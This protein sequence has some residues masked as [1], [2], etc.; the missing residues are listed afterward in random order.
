MS[1]RTAVVAALLAAAGG[2]LAACSSPLAS[3]LSEE[4]A[5][6]TNDCSTTGQNTFVYDT[7]KDIYYWYREMPSV[8][9]G[10]YASP[11]ALL[12]AVRNKN[13]D[14]AFSYIT[15]QAANDAFFSDSQ[16]IGFGF[17]SRLLSS[18]EWAVTDVYPDGSA[19]AVGLR[20]GARILEVNG[21]TAAAIIAANETGSV[22]GPSE[23]GVTSTI[24]FRTLEGQVIEG[25]MTKRLVTIPTVGLTQTYDVGGRRVGYV[26]FKNFVQP[27]TAA[28]DA[29]FAQLRREGANELVL[30]VRYNGGGLVSVAQHLGNLIGGS[31]TDGKVFGQY[32]HNDRNSHRNSTMR[33]GSAANALGLSRA[34]VIT[35][36]A[37]ASA[38]ELII[39]GLRPFVD[40][41]TVGDATYGKPVG[42]YGYTFCAKV[43][44]PVAFS[45]RNALNEG[46]YFGGIPANCPAADDVNRAFG[47]PA[48]ASLATAL[49]YVRTGSCNAAAATAYRAQAERAARLRQPH[50]EDG[51]Q[52]LLVA[53]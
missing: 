14:P 33:F 5:T 37:S 16:F 38:S 27:S 18:T 15:T 25:Q 45:I 36:R 23:V 46:D 28:L 50:T 32:V 43:F 7:M 3:L 9:P 6:S 21:R 22:F 39:N 4:T 34:V 40:V 44:Y 41:R 51:W 8:S 1:A 17:S 53:H 31:V 20:R 26:V 24:R 11:D 19:Y 48:E 42:Q 13:L 10:S 47:D 49:G 52:Q 12:E 30:D 2:G 35:T 29:S